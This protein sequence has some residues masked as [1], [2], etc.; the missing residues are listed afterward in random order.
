M[1]EK[2]AKIERDKSLIYHKYFT[3]TGIITKKHW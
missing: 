3:V 1:T 2:I